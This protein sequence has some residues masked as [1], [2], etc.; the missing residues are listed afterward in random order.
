MTANVTV[1]HC[2]TTCSRRQKCHD[3]IGLGGGG[4]QKPQQASV[5]RW[6]NEISQ[7]LLS[8]EWWIQTQAIRTDTCAW[9]SFKAAAARLSGLSE[10]PSILLLWNKRAPSAQTGE[11]GASQSRTLGWNRSQSAVALS[12]H[13]PICL[14]V[15]RTE[16]QVKGLRG[17]KDRAEDILTPTVRKEERRAERTAVTPGRKTFPCYGLG[18]PCEDVR[19]LLRGETDFTVSPSAPAPESQIP[20]P[21]SPSTTVRWYTSTVQQRERATKP[22]RWSREY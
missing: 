10:N 16:T 14:S 8:R 22:C 2:P 11:D 1:N 9:T 7:S 13:P 3:K 18:W 21:P 4:W 20:P 6:D 19:G 12:L 5:K 15:T 17:Q